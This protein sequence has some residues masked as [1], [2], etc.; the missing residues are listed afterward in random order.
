[1][2]LGPSRV[3]ASREDRGFSDVFLEN[4]TR[5]ISPTVRE[6]LVHLPEY[7]LILPVKLAMISYCCQVVQVAL[8]AL[9]VFSPWFDAKIGQR[10]QRIV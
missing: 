2:C 10:W 8:N 6:L 3:G 1:M 5:K 7:D 9:D 4:P